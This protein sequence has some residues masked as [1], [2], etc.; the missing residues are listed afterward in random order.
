MKSWTRASSVQCQWYPGLHQQKG[1]QQG[2]GGDYPS[3][4]C[5]CE[6][7]SGVLHPGLGP[8]AQE[9]W[10]VVG[11]SPEESHKDDQRAGA[12]LLWRQPEGLGIVQ[13]GE[14]KTLT[15]PHCDLL[16]LERSL[17]AGGGPKF[18]TH[19]LWQDKGKGFKV[20]EG[21]FRLDVRKQ[22]FTRRVVR[23][24]HRLPSEVVNAP[25]LKALKVRFDG[26]LGSLI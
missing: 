26:F 17:Q 1:G 10:G 7:P 16:M 9:G 4:L 12:P 3:P 13:L 18:Y 2:K 11:A 15:R 6:A 22:F 5:P 25:T 24:W 14:E 19:R 23:H 8:P 20:K 21:R